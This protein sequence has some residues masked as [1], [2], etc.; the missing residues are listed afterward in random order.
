MT[1][2]G[3]A[4]DDASNERAKVRSFDHSEFTLER[5]ATARA[6]RGLSVSLCRPARDDGAAV[7]I[8]SHDERIV[9]FVDRVVAVADGRCG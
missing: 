6:E 5:I 2:D 3:R 7:I 8:A 9:P 1:A 4:A